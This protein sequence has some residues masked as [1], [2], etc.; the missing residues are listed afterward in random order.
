MRL[1]ARHL[2]RAVAEPTDKVA[3]GQMLLAANIAGMRSTRPAFGLVHAMAHVVGARHGVHHGTANA[4]CLPPRHPFN[5]NE[6]AAAT[7]TSPRRSASTRAIRRRD[8]GRSGGASGGAPV[9][10][11]QAAVEA[12]RGRRAEGDLDACAEARSPTAPSST[13]ASSPPRRISCS[14]STETRIE[15]GSKP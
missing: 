13:T 5:A 15:R 14:A 10:P 2:P 4:I 6:L 3:R 1:I 9:D 11:H 8:G 12:A 7:A